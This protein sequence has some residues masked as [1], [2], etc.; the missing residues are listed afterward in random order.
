MP[1]AFDESERA[2][3][4]RRLRQAGRRLFAAQGV[5]KTSVENLT[6]AAG[7][8]KGSLY[9]FYLN[10]ELL[11]FE[12]LEESQKRPNNSCSYWLYQCS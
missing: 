8:A 6:A 1:R 11:F 7:I 9:K 5:V 10:K 4:T 3:I 12:L 2:G